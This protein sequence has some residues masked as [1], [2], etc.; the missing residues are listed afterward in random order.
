MLDI[1]G[2]LLYVETEKWYCAAYYY[3]YYY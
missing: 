3:Y 1:Y 2:C